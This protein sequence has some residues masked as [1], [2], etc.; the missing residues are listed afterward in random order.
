MLFNQITENMWEAQTQQHHACVTVQWAAPQLSCVT[1][2]TVL[3]KNFE[4]QLLFDT[5]APFLDHF[6]NAATFL[7]SKQLQHFC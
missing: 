7:L 6:H 4:H 3:E 5:I 1:R 2:A